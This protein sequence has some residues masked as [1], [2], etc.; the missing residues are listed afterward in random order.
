MH[1]HTVSQLALLGAL[2]ELSIVIDGAISTYDGSEVVVDPALLEAV[3]RLP[4][5]RSLRFDG[6][7][8]LYRGDWKLRTGVAPEVP[9]L[10]G[11]Q[12][13]MLQSLDLS[14]YMNEHELTSDVALAG[15]PN[16]KVLSCFAPSLL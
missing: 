13:A 10:A 4:G 1:M 7:T 14:I 5:L 9:A 12:A 15:L 11:L 8:E 16:L 2:H 6:F 3:F